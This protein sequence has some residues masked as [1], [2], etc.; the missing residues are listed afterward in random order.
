MLHRSLVLALRSD[1]GL[2]DS[3]EPGPENLLLEEVYTLSLYVFLQ[4]SQVLGM[5][6]G[7]EVREKGH[8]ELEQTNSTKENESKHK[9]ERRT[10]EAQERKTPCRQGN[11]LWNVF[12]K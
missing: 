11:T 4:V 12:K 8:K 1:L 2:R 9:K 3:V 10:P 7:T 5:R 6:K